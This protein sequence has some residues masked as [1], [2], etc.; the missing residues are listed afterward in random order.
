M[1][2]PP[3]VRYERLRPAQIVARRE[4]CPIG[5]L[6]IGSAVFSTTRRATLARLAHVRGGERTR[7]NADQRIPADSVCFFDTNGLDE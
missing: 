4:A 2:T 7:M 6:P 5:W 1:D 3:L